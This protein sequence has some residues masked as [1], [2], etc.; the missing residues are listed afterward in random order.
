[1]LSIDLRSLDS[2]AT[3]IDAVLA[4]DDTVWLETDDRPASGVQVT[5]RLST[6]GSKRYYFSGRI[7]GTAQN[8]CRRC[9]V[10]VDVPVADDVHV[11]F[12]ESDGEDSEDSDVYIIDAHDYA[13]DL[14]PA[15]REQWLLV[16][17]SLVVCRDDCKGLCPTCGTDLNLGACSCAPTRDPRWDVLGSLDESAR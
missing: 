10:D 4:A 7:E 14:R 6:A 16:V 13:L 12:A 17:P 9:L 8:T 2:H 3:L 5:G 1:M 11:L 15:I